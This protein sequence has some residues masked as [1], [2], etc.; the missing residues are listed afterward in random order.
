MVFQ[1]PCREDIDDEDRIFL[2]LDRLE[3]VA[4]VFDFFAF[5]D[6]IL[7]VQQPAAHRIHVFVVDV[8]AEQ[9]V[10]IVDQHAGTDAV[11]VLAKHDEFR[12]IFRLEIIAD[13]ADDFLH[14]VLHR[15]E[16]AC[17]AVFVNQNGDLIV[18][19]LHLDQEFLDR[20]RFDDRDDRANEIGD[21]E[22]AF[23]LV[24]DSFDKCGED[25][26]WC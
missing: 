11:M 23:V 7:L 25:F 8:Q 15:N 26:L 4:V 12:L 13:V 9:V 22:F 5:L 14:D 17:A 10:D 16:A 24:L 6:V 21:G 18:F 1:L 3:A 2:F 20:N 19:L